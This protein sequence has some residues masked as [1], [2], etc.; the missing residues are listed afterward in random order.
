MRRILLLI[1]WQFSLLAGGRL[2][3]DVVTLK[4][5]RQISGLVESGNTQELHIKVGDQSQTIDI[6]QVQA[7]QFGVSLPVPAAAPPP[8]K[9]AALSP[10]PAP[11]A[12]AL[13]LNDG[14]GAAIVAAASGGTTVRPGAVVGKLTGDDRKIAPKTRCTNTLTTPAFSN[15]ERG[16]Q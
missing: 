8:P 2:F 15:S 14:T 13:T 16:R 10:R 9:A 3:A 6:H 1:F 7:I 11:A 5:G 4:D 12:V